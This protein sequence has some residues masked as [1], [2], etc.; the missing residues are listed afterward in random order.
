MF[1]EEISLRGAPQFRADRPRNCVRSS[2]GDPIQAKR[3]F[4]QM[5][6]PKVHTLPYH[7]IPGHTTPCHTIWYDMVWYGVVWYGMVWYGVVWC[8][9]VWY[10]VVWCGLVW[11]GVVCPSDGNRALPESGPH[12]S[13]GH[14]L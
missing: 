6:T 1:W 11:F 13:S 2:R 5:G 7:T 14:N 4:R 3:D 12:E 8:G 10:G 9:M